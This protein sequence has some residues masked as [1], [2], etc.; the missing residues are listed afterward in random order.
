MI[1]TTKADP[2]FSARLTPHRALSRRGRMVVVALVAVL[3]GIPSIVFFSLGAWPVL[4]FLG[5]DVAAVWLALTLSDRSGKRFEQ[6]TLYPDRLEV[7][8]VSARGREARARFRPSAVR[9][10]VERNFDER[11]TSLKLRSPERELEIGTFLDFA[12]RASFARAFGTALR[13]A[14]V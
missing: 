11:V 9:L 12:D 1:A 2:I 6:V 10:L 7:L 4:G 8:Q 13:K 14:R 3:A 5:L